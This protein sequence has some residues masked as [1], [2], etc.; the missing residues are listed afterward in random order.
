MGF[1]DRVASGEGYVVGLWLR[2]SP[3]SVQYGHV[4]DRVAI[5]EVQ[6]GS[7]WLPGG[8]SLPVWVVLTPTKG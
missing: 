4:G 6:A 1:V 7:I 3:V 5:L 2:L 8:V